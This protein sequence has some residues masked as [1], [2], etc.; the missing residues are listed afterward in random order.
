MWKAASLSVI[1]LTA[2]A[3]APKTSRQTCD[4]NAYKHLLGQGIETAQF[5]A[6]LDHRIIYPNTAVTMD[7]KPERLNI[8]VTK[9]GIVEDLRCG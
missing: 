5:P 3:P 6:S 7:Y 4:A 9:Q 2:C 1:L 8:H